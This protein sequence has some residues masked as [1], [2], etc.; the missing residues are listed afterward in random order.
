MKKVGIW[1]LCCLLVAVALGATVDER[2]DGMR[3]IGKLQF[4]QQSWASGE[5][6]AATVSMNNANMLIERMD[7]IV[8]DAT[9]GITFTVTI[10][11]ENSSQILSEASLAENASNV[12]LATKS[13]ADFDA[14][15]VNNTLTAT[16]TPSGDPG[17]SGVT[18]DV[19]LYGH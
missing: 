11:D 14:V 17:A 10:T 1:L 18:V 3:P 7:V 15:P 8:S 9:N 16:I 4:T 6:A 13:T 5:T 12:L 19:I 2:N